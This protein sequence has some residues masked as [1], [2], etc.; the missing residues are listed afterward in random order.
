M[1]VDTNPRVDSDD[2][3]QQPEKFEAI[4]EQLA[5][6]F[7]KH[8]TLDSVTDAGINVLVKGTFAVPRAM[9][10]LLQPLAQLAG[11][12]LVAAEEPVLPIFAAFLVPII[13]NM[14]GSEADAAMFSSRG[15]RE[16]RGSAAAGL[17]EAYMTAL[18]GDEAGEIEPGDAG[19]KRIA[20]AGVHAALEGWFNGWALEMLGDLIPWE[21]LKFKDLTKLPE[22]IISSLGVSRL[23]RRAFAPLVDATAATPMKRFA[24]QKYRPNLLNE[25]DIARAFISGDYTAEQAAD[26]LAQLGYSDQRQDIILKGALKWMSIADSLVL[27]RDGLNDRS[28]A[29]QNARLQGYDDVGAEAAVL[30]E[31][32]KHLN[33]IRDD[34]AAA[35]KSAY[36]DRRIDDGQ[37]DTYLAAIYPS[38]EDRSAYVTAWRTIRDLNTKR[39]SP[40]EALACV[41]AKVLPIAAY[42]EALTL[43][44]YNDEAVLALEL[45]LETELN[46]QAD[47]EKLRDQ[48][49]ADAAAAKQAAADAAAQKAADVDAA[50]ELAKR[51][52]LADLKRAVIRG[53]IPTSRYEEVLTPQYDGDTVATLVA[54]V[55]QERA[56]YVAQQQK[57]DDATKRA[58][59]RHIDVGALQTAYLDDVLT[60]DQVRQQLASLSF[61]PADADILIATMQ[62]KKADRD[63]ATKQRAEAAAKA[64][65]KSID[66][67]RFETLVRRGH[68]TV[69][70]YGA[71]LTSLGYDAGSVAAMA[72][73]L[74]LEIAD[75]TAAR[76]ARA[77]AAA[78]I[79]AQGL[80]LEQMRRAV[81]LGSKS[82]DDFQRYLI[83]NK[84][85][86]D[87]QGVLLAEL[88]NDVAEADAAR[89]KREA[90]A[91]AS[92]Q[93]RA[94]LAVIERAARLGIVTPDVYEARLRDANYSDDDIAIE[95]DLLAVEIADTQAARAKAAAAEAKTEDRGLSLDQLAR[96][97]KLGAAS[98][99]DYTARAVELGYAADDVD[100]LVAV[101]TADVQAAADAQ[102]RHDAIDGQMKARNLSLSELDDAVKNNLM[103]VDAYNAKLVA[104]GFGQDDADLLTTLLVL[105]LP[106]T[107]PGA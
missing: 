53:L 68:R 95:L 75:D 52:S 86:V 42:R 34:S 47:V 24:N 26:E 38:D 29:I 46:G 73:L 92:V 37:L 67:G 83:D 84:Y 106:A 96:A 48:K 4:G 100:T 58:A 78:K 94:P 63:A 72:D 54:L 39:L 18:A 102:A 40:A 55:E 21:W 101:L 16:A 33:A 89:T 104:L 5:G 49:T 66:L 20:G 41:K 107:A 6:G 50:R 62:A 85:T 105:K 10:K 9:L 59:L 36:V 82:E 2:P 80:T 12:A 97:V 23:T 57:A 17:V 7:F 79:S 56:D 87:A 69:A 3:S 76:D 93:T 90:A 1:S 27:V 30:V 28:L 19:A 25:G 51:G 74:Q 99:D 14:F 98:M 32:V 103:A 11:E 81:I 77:A 13:Q 65:T 22:D 88:R 35:V 64:A 8:F 91:A 71:L 31:E 70:D 15:N 45:L 43:D 60:L 44:G 61:A